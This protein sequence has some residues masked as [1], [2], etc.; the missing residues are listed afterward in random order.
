MNLTVPILFGYYCERTVGCIA[1][2][3]VCAENYLFSF[4]LCNLRV[5]RVVGIFLNAEEGLA[6]MAVVSRP[7][8]CSTSSMFQ[9]SGLKEL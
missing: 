3:I 5:F 8:D 7:P 6:E 1:C 9:F 2:C 4:F